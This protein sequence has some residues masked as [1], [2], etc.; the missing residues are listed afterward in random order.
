M[1]PVPDDFRPLPLLGNPHV[2]TLLGTFL[3]GPAPRLVSH[4]YRVPLSD[5]DQLVL[6]DSVPPG[7]QPGGRIALLVHGLGGDHR[8]SFLVR[9]ARRLLS[10]GVRVFRLD[11]RGCGLGIALARRPYHAGCSDDVRAAVEAIHRS[12]PSSPVVLL[13]GSLGGNIVLK[14]A[15]EAAD[16]PV[17]G[18]ERVAAVSPP[19]DLEGCAALIAL[20][21]NRLYEKHFVQTLLHLAQQRARLFPDLPAVRFP[22]RMTLRLFD[23]LYTAP[24]SG[25]RDALDYYRRAAALPFIPRI[26]VPTLILTARDDPFITPDPFEQL[27]GL[28]AVRVRVLTQGGHLGFIGRDGTGGIRWAEQRL[29]EW[30][31]RFDEL[32]RE[33]RAVPSAAASVSR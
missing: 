33:V 20:P 26:T 10:Q 9:L 24:L 1:S 22:R 3:S 18:L 2:Q 11:L 12:S 19:I 30:V 5:G 17:P 25:F 27:E 32:W 28:P 23:E 31:C 4:P 16:R 7:W 8:S 21:R 13:G 29:V 14:L 6:H 15:G